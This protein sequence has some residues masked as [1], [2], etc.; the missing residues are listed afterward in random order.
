MIKINHSRI[1]KAQ[2]LMKK[3]GMMGIMIMNHDDYI[4]FFNDLR[5]Q[6]R[7]IIPA[8]GP[9]ILIGF[10]AE[11][12]ELKEQIENSE[13]RLFSHIGEQISNVREVFK[14][15]FEGPPP[16]MIHQEHPKVG[17]QMWFHT[18]AFLV[19]LFRK[20]NKQVELVPSDPVMDALRMIKDE[21]EIE[22]MRTA[23]SIAA[24]GMDTARKLLRPGITGHELATEI[25]YAMMKAGAEGTSTP[26]HI[27]SGKRSCWIHGTVTHEPIREGEMTVIDLTPQYQG[28]CSNL[29]RTFVLGPPDDVQKRLFETYFKM[30]KAIVKELKPGNSVSMLD[31]IGKEICT[32]NGFGEH[33][34]KGISHGIGLRFEENPASTI[35]PAHSKTKFN[36]NMTLTVGHTILAL[37]GVGGVRFED[38]YMVTDEGGEVL[39]AY[40][41]DYVI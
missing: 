4:Y 24:V 15:L 10:S 28:Y 2:E 30:Y 12:E 5:V 17:M 34:I 7:A 27:N 20:V 33:H 18:P 16:D 11:E 8:S 22:K 14:K 9:P 19:D 21:E 35:I 32:E 38:I 25:T 37:P 40:P 23:Q 13:I 6:P 41:F 26:I 31:N 1:H 39:H 36:K 29:A 3:E